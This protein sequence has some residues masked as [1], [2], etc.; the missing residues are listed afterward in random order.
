M[1]MKL[2]IKS[3]VLSNVQRGF[4]LIELM[5]S[6]LIGL[7]IL[8]AVIGMFVTMVKADNDY[9]KSIR[10]N[11]ELRAAMS[12][13][14]RDLRRSGYNGTASA[15]VIAGTANPFQE[16]ATTTTCVIYAYDVNNNG[17]N[18]GNSERFGFRLS[19][20]GVA[21]ESRESGENCAATTNWDNITDENLVK[22]TAFSVS[23]PDLVGDDPEE[24]V[25]PGK[26][27]AGIT[28]HQITISLTG[29][30]VRDPSVTRTISET[31]EI[32]N[33]EY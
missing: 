21:I 30:L 28:T 6:M 10:L 15:T 32:R 8:A 27:S 31:V 18:D 9:L 26:T 25:T 24:T 2:A 29:R 17:I 11:Q 16:M 5:I 33:D 19:L 4:T 23:D 7:I 13:I 22:I 14:T 1:L 20:N 3:K 12:L